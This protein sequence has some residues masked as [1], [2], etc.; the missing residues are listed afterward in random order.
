MFEHIFTQV[1][2]ALLYFFQLYATLLTFSSSVSSLWN[3]PAYMTFLITLTLLE[4]A[5]Y[6]MAEPQY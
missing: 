4:Y 6:L 3:E 5:L 1:T 2:S